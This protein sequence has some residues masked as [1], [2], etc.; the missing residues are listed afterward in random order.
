MK[1]TA[2]AHCARDRILPPVGALQVVREFLDITS[3]LE[4]SS[5]SDSQIWI[6]Q[7]TLNAFNLDVPTKFSI[8]LELVMETLLPFVKNNLW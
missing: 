6:L 1:A 8:F 7:V 5:D 2:S 4:I 3:Y